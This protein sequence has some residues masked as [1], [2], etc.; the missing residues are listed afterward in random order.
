M[1]QN[2]TNLKAS[3]LPVPGIKCQ[4]PPTLGFL[5]NFSPVE[6]LMCTQLS[7]VRS[8]W[9][10]KGF[11]EQ[12][13]GDA[14]PPAHTSGAP[15]LWAAQRSGCLPKPTSPAGCPQASSSHRELTPTNH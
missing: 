10:R 9:D 3:I 15:G 13:S 6:K 8:Y 14:A 12:W 5:Q 7:Q 11:P 4:E 2:L 1:G